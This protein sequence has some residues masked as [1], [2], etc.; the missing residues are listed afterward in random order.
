MR[1]SEFF[2]F[3]TFQDKLAEKISLAHGATG[4]TTQIKVMRSDVQRACGF[5]GNPTKHSAV[6]MEAQS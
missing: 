6:G 5:R 1:D 3:V 4:S 2:A